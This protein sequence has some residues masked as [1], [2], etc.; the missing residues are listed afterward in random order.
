MESIIWVGSRLILIIAIPIVT[1][2]IGGYVAHIIE[3][4]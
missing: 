3:K 1:G 2:I 4:K